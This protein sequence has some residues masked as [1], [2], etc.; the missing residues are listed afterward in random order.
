M[1]LQYNNK[2][3]LF[4]ISAETTAAINAL[5]AEKSRE[6][7]EL[8]VRLAEV[9][10]KYDSELAE[11]V[12]QNESLVTDYN[13]VQTEL[14]ELRNRYAVDSAQLAASNETKL[15]AVSKELDELK[16]AYEKNRISNVSNEARVQVLD[17]LVKELQSGSAIDSTTLMD[18]AKYKTE[19]VALSKEKERLSDKLDGE[20]DARKLLE[21]HVKVISEEMNTL[22]QGFSLAEKDKLEAQTR[23]EVLS[24]YFKEKE[25]QLQK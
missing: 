7:S 21:D 16:I 11:V 12:N 19:I 6:N 4:K 20:Q 13:Q 14:E 17:Q 18:S 8:Q 9:S 3:K 5:L 1:V 22:R 25:M 23:L 15:S 2:I 24:T 10:D